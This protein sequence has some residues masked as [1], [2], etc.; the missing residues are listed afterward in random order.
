MSIL[1][2]DNTASSESNALGIFDMLNTSLS[3]QIQT[4]ESLLQELQ[5]QSK[6]KS[7]PA[8]KP[9][10]NSKAKPKQQSKQQQQQQQQQHEEEGEEEKVEKVEKPRIVYV[11][12]L[13][14]ELMK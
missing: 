8:P 12:S 13:M 6:P 1:L 3:S 9:K 7:K 2:L 14:I 4:E 5:F 10:S 11:V